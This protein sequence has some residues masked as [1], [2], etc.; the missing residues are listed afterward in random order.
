MTFTEFKRKYQKLET[1]EREDFIERRIE[2]LIN[3]SSETKLIGLGVNGSFSSFIGPEVQIVSN[4][5]KFFS[6]L[7]LDDQNVYKEFLD[8]IDNNVQVRLY[9][10]P[11]TIDAIQRF[12]WKYFGY[13]AGSVLDRMDIY[14]DG[15]EKI[16]IKAF[17]GRNIATCSERSALVHNILKFLGFE[18]EIIFGKLNEKESHAYVVFKIEGREDRILYDPMNPIA[19]ETKN[20]T[21]YCPAVCM[22]SD[23]EYKKLKN[24]DVFDFNYDLVR[25]IYIGEAP[26]GDEPR[27]YS[28][29]DKKIVINKGNVII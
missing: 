12:I 1:T 3:E 7:V 13:N 6:N 8:S 28:C 24:G 16:S 17:K 11:I 21:N 2:E 18:S 9:G 10:E 4:E 29:D 20:G 15:Y 25:K 19:Y 27:S 14:S 5:T 23:E 26:S 22:V